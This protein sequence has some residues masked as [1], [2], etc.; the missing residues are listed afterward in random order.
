M[1]SFLD[2]RT[3]AWRP[4]VVAISLFVAACGGGGGSDAPAPQPEQPQ[5]PALSLFSGAA[6]IPGSQDGAAADARFRRP[7]ALAIAPSGALYVGDLNPSGQALRIMDE[8]GAASSVPVRRTD[9]L[10]NIGPS[11]RAMAVDGQG[12]VYT[13]SEAMLR[14]DP[15]AVFK[16]TPAGDAAVL[17]DLSAWIGPFSRTDGA[18][19]YDYHYKGAINGL[20]VDA[21]GNVYAS[22][23]NGVILRIDPRGGAAVFAGSP[24]VLGHVDGNAA[25]A[26]FGVLG[27]MA[28]DPAGNLYV[29]DG[30]HDGITGIG[31]TIRKISPAGMVSTVAGRADQ[32]A[33]LAD[34]PAD[35]A[36]F[37][38]AE[39]TSWMHGFT[40]QGEDFGNYP[41]AW[42]GTASLALDGKGNLYVTDPVN[43]VIRQITPNGQVSTVVG[44]AGQRGFAAGPLPGVIDLPVG[45]AVR[46]SRLYFT[47]GSAVARVGLPQ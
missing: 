21:S 37:S 41:V 20:A 38:G 16:I 19:T 43:S 18:Y 2:L 13:A 28:F 29:V 46:G 31:P 7:L 22:G 36:R 10:R 1:H 11:W 14:D 5:P 42:G 32:P 24:G 39:R 44:Q 34:G 26:R 47:T 35:S 3:R 15:R 30:L 8:D 45:I 33:G 6:A 40:N 25:D 4:A 27:N 23:V 9:D 17:A 12:N